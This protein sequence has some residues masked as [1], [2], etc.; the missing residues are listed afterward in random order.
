MT[1]TLPDE[2][3][4]MLERNAAAAGF[5]TVDEYIAD[6]MTEDYEAGSSLPPHFRTRAEFDRLVEEGLASGP[7]VV[8][9]EAFWTERRRVLAEKLAGHTGGAS[10]ECGL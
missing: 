5:A 10:H 8:A 7:S 9:D 6:A 2:M 1:I 3:R 4:S